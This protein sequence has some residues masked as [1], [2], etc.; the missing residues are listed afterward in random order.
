MN[1]EARPV[2]EYVVFV[3]RAYTKEKLAERI[4]ERLNYYEPEDIISINVFADSWVTPF[5]R[6]NSAVITVRPSA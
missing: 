6:R 5:W 3:V 1:N 4:Q 2:S